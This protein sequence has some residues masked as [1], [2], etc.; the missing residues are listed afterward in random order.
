MDHIEQSSARPDETKRPLGGLRVAKN[1]SPKS[2]KR[3]V[4]DRCT[5]SIVKSRFFRMMQRVELTPG[6]RIFM[7]GVRRTYRTREELRTNLRTKWG[8]LK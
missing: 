5:Q 6:A 3:A 2:L 1:A 4:F 8:R 7:P